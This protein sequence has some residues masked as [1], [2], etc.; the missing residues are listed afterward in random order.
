[1]RIGIEAKWLFDGPPSGQ[2]VVRNLVRS[3]S[4]VA[5]DDELHLFLD[6]RSR[7]TPTPVDPDRCH[8]VWAGNNQLSNVFVVP[9]VA[10]R[11]GLDSVVY[12]NFVPPRQT[13]R[14][15]RVAFVHDAIFDSHPSFFTWRERLYF[16][17]LR[18]LTATA[19]RVCT[20]S[21]SERE[22]LVRLGYAPADRVD[23]VP[24]AV[25][26]GFAHG[27]TDD[28]LLAD[29]GVRAPYVL[30]VGR[31][32]VRKNV[33]TLVRALALT[34]SASLTLVIAGA[35]DGT[36]AD[37]G[38]VATEAG[39]ADRVQ[40]LGPVSDELLRALYAS[41]TVFCFPSLDEGFGLSPLEAMACG[42]PTVVSDHPALRETCGDAAI[43][44]DPL[45]PAAIAS[46]IDRL[47]DDPSART[48]LRDLG[49]ARVQTF[50]WEASARRLLESLHEAARSRA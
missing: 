38:D 4:D 1:M 40:L 17:P 39:V 26:D 35:P 7:G 31:L 34:R 42:T 29:V 15:A 44:V 20:V 48:R 41:A 10:D 33:A 37:L 11:L 23:V 16:K 28:V 49:L 2:R 45:D 21:E 47:M 32:N 9:R 50:S 30:Y 22:R 27:S 36:S 14:H 13:A 3:L 6:E 24:N 46:A 8:Y 18:F 5:G 43:Y 19:D 12:Q 25:G